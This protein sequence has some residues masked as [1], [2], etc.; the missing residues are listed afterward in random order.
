MSKHI[1]VKIDNI[2][3]DKNVLNFY[4]ETGKFYGVKISTFGLF[5]IVLVKHLYGWKKYVK[6]KLWLNLKQNASKFLFTCI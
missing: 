2:I 1:V 4:Q 5:I 6:Q 3:Y